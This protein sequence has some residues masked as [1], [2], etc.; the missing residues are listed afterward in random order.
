MKFFIKCICSKLKLIKIF[1]LLHIELYH[2]V[3]YHLLNIQLKNYS[4]IYNI[5]VI[6][7]MYKIFIILVK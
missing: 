3:L 5:I 6:N 7:I 2:I 4:Y 1:E